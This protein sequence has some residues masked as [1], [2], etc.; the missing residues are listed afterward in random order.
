MS[1][2]DFIKAITDGIQPAPAYFF[3]DALL[4]KQGYAAYS[5]VTAEGTKPLT[6]LDFE[7]EVKNGAIVID[8]RT[9]DEFE[10]GFVPGSV[11]IGLNG[12]YAIWAATLFDI[13]DRIV[14][15]T[16]PGK[17]GES[18]ER[19][20]RVGF[21][22]IAGCLKGGF[23]AWQAA[24]KRF[25]MIISI[26]AEEFELDA[27]HTDIDILDVRKPGEW[28][29]KHLKRA[30]HVPLDSLNTNFTKL[31]KDKEYL[32]HCAGGYRSMIAASYLKTKGFQRVKNVW[33]GFGVIQNLPLEF[34]SAAGQKA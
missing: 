21:D 8:S 6:L 30:Q 27:K 22:N 16:T 25:D 17:E 9:P 20:T 10:N 34:E 33:G 29:E 12:Q 24:D 7:N 31:D 19:L 23:E 13:H 4:N 32:I 5:E 26:D 28:N 3:K 18:V 1:K 2:E 14:L 11:N 15:V